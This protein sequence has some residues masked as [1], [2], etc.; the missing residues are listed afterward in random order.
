VKQVFFSRPF[1]SRETFP[2]RRLPMFHVKQKLFLK[3]LQQIPNMDAPI[4][5]EVVEPFD[6]DR[7][8]FRRFMK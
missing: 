3:K 4:R 2:R 1:V 7:P 6:F 5:K 8:N